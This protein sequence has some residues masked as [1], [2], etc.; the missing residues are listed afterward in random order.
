MTFLG[1]LNFLNSKDITGPLPGDVLL[2]FAREEVPLLDDP[3]AL[4]FEWYPEGLTGLVGPD[5]VAT[6]AW[7]FVVCYGH[8][9]RTVDFPDTQPRLDAE[10]RMHIPYML[11]VLEGTKIGGVPPFRMEIEEHGGMPGRY[12]ASIGTICPALGCPYPWMNEPSPYA[13]F[14]SDEKKGMRHCGA[15]DELEW[16]DAGVLSLFLDEQNEIRWS[17]ECY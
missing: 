10:G 7:R 3:D 8:R 17:I 6:P 2:V 16:G 14:A 9:H 15:E 12:L 5:A 11:S 13:V 1:Q 4:R